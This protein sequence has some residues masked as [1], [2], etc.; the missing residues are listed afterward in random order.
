MAKKKDTKTE[1]KEKK[2]G[3]SCNEK[4]KHYS[5]IAKGEKAVKSDSKF[6]EAEQRAYARGQRDARNESRRLWKIRN[7]K[8]NENK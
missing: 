7:A 1:N 3:F 8:N 6:T 2:K 5:E 4:L